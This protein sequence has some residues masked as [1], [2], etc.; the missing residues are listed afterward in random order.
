MNRTIIALRNDEHARTVTQALV[1]RGITV[2]QHCQN[3]AEVIRIIKEMGGGIIICSFKLRD[4]TACELADRLN[5]QAFLLV[6]AKGNQLSLCE[7]DNIFT[8]PLPV[9]G[10][11]LIGA[12]TMLL[13]LDAHNT[14]RSVPK[15]NDIAR[16]LVDKAKALLMQRYGMTEPEAHRFL[17][18]RS[19]RTSTRM[20]DTARALL[21]EQ[22]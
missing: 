14:S 15:R 3:G 7:R 22:S 17:Q 13:Q 18:Q 5:G 8:M 16:L 4:M 2:R 21:N 20:E 1:H 6:L 9:R 19:M 10:A 11:E 12:V